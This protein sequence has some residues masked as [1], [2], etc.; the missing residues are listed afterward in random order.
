[1]V[2]FDLDA[3][4]PELMS[5]R[6]IQLLNAYHRQVRESILPRLTDEAERE[7]LIHATREI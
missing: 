4:M 1:M 3:V 7:W 2:P 5:S 6:D